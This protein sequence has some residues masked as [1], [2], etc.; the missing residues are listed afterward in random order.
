[1]AKSPPPADPVAKRPRGRPTV[2]TA[3]AADEIAERIAAGEALRTICADAHLPTEGAVRMWVVDDREG[4][5]A[6]YA[7][8]RMAQA[9]G[10]ADEI[11]TIADNQDIDWQRSRL[12][13]DTRKWIVSKLLPRVYGDKLA[14][15]TSGNGGVTVVI[16]K[17]EGEE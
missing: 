1:M 4:F 2:Y 16:R 10:W 6:R 9:V 5:A 14:V 12:M 3:A 15:E 7:R 13:T 8:A 17:F 11:V